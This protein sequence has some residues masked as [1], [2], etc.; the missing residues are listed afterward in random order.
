MGVVFFCFPVF[1]VFFPGEVVVGATF[2][3]DICWILLLYD[4]SSLIET[5]CSHWDSCAFFGTVGSVSV[6]EKLFVA[7]PSQD[8]AEAP[9]LGIN[10]LRFRWKGWPFQ[11]N[12]N[13]P[14]HRTPQAIPLPNYERNP[15]L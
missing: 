11:E 5:L 3:L 12:C 10:N 8:R 9:E 2:L 15:D 6:V 13:T 7:T 4:I 1:G 14:L